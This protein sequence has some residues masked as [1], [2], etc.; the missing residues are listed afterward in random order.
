[1]QLISD[2]Y[3]RIPAFLANVSCALVGASRKD[4]RAAF[5][6]EGPFPSDSVLNITFEKPLEGSSFI[7]FYGDYE[8]MS[9][10]RDEQ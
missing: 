1:M 8:T 2:G 5:I 7:A 10:R 3:S 6:R 4:I 9:E